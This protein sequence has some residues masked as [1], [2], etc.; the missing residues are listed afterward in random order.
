MNDLSLV[1]R[2]IIVLLH[3]YLGILTLN[4][5]II[6]STCRIC[7][8]LILSKICQLVVGIDELIDNILLFLILLQKKLFQ[9]HDLFVLMKGY[10]FEE[11][12]ILV[13]FI[14]II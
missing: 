10:I 1:P 4:A 5:S 12:E 8:W 3:I 2:I 14:Q 7:W 9:R 13:D 6:I 11:P